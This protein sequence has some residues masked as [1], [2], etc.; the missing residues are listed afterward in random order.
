[1]EEYKKLSFEEEE[2][3][4]KKSN[5]A[6]WGCIIFFGL[7]EFLVLILHSTYVLSFFQSFL[8]AVTIAVI[9][10][11]VTK[12]IFDK[13]EEP[14]TDARIAQMMDNLKKEGEVISKKKQLNYWLDIDEEEKTVQINGHFYNFREILNYRLSDHQKQTPR[15][16]TITS[17]SKT[18]TGSMLGRAVVGG[19][20]GGTAGAIIG[21]ATAKKK[22]TTSI[23]TPLFEEPHD[24]RIVITVDNI[25][26]STETLKIGN[27]E[28][29]AN[30]VAATLDIII[31][32]S[33]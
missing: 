15:G 2:V 4:K 11:L 17:E 30:K 24:Y 19:M 10:F 12:K 23:S 26:R 7:L 14:I 27:N 33:R 20:L 29:M 21:G 28:E 22:T 9:G 5:I 31:S 6:L 25:A 1:M 18:D 32:R 8:I 13:I 3:I 16:G